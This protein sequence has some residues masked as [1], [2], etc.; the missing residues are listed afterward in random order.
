MLLLRMYMLLDASLCVLFAMLGEVSGT[1]VC[2]GSV[3]F[4][5]PLKAG[6]DLAWLGSVVSA[7]RGRQTDARIVTGFLLSF[8]VGLVVLAVA[9]ESCWEGDESL[10]QVKT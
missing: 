7:C 9:P 6:L 8:L 4:W 10:I 5:I 1:Q 3:G 2:G